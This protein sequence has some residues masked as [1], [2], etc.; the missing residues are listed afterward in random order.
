MTD[1]RRYLR[2]GQRVEIFRAHGDYGDKRIA[3]TS[4]SIGIITEIDPCDICQ[5]SRCNSNNVALKDTDY[6]CPGYMT[7]RVTSGASLG[8]TL[9]RRCVGYGTY[10]LYKPIGSYVSRPKNITN[11]HTKWINRSIPK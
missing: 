9:N 7:V 1:N 2:V 10:F 3:N 5:G 11:Q 6:K 8:Q 4:S